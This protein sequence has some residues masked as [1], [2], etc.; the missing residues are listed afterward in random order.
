MLWKLAIYWTM[1]TVTC[2]L[3]ILTA[4]VFVRGYNVD[5]TIPVIKTGPAG[6][7]FG[8]SVAQHQQVR[9]KDAF[10]ATDEVIGN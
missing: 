8:Y 2:I 3:I 7:Y 6:S 10:T 4:C 1:A 9:M 5:T